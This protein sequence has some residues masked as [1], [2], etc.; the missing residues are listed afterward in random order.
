MWQSVLMTSFVVRGWLYCVAVSIDDVIRCDGDGFIVWQSVYIT[1][2]VVS[3]WLYCVAVSIDNV[4]CCEWMALLCGSQYCCW[5]TL[6]YFL[7][8]VQRLAFSP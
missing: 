2:F 1:S 7:G 3:G 4:I 5:M 6:V 8:E